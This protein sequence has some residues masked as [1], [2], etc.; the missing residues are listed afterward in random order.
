MNWDSYLEFLLEY[1]VCNKYLIKC[2][3]QFLLLFMLIVISVINNE[4]KISYLGTDTD[5]TAIEMMQFY[6]RN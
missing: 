1:L 6:V 5:I 2:T 4:E 3:Y